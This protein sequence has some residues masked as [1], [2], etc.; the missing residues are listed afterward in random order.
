MYL[1]KRTC[2]LSSYRNADP[3]KRC[4]PSD[5]ARELYSPNAN[6]T[7]AMT[8][9]QTEQLSSA[10]LE[11]TDLHIRCRA[12]PWWGRIFTFDV[13][14]R[15]G[16]DGSSHLMLRIHPTGA[17][18]QPIPSYLRQAARGWMGAK[19]DAVQ[20]S[21]RADNGEDCV[22]GCGDQRETVPCIRYDEMIP[23]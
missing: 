3:S 1:N 6:A 9:S 7:P 4:T 2:C 15:P 23:C 21:T 16:G 14:R 18:S 12:P 22:V 20:G 11:G 17:D 8:K 19:K 10:A 5:L 13:K